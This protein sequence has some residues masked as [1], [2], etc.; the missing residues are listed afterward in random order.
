MN[1]Q[2]IPILFITQ[3][4]PPMSHI[5]AFRLFSYVK[6]FR[7]DKY[8][9]YVIARKAHKNLPGQAQMEGVSITY[10]E[11]DSLI[12]DLTIYKA[13]NRFHHKLISLKNKI[14][15]NFCMDE[16]PDFTQKAYKEA[17][18]MITDKGIRVVVTSFG[19]LSM[20]L[21]GIKI[22]Q[23]FKDVLWVSDLRDEV[24][25]APKISRLLKPRITKV[26]ASMM[27]LADIVVSV[28]KPILSDL[29]D[30]EFFKSKCLEV[31]NGFDFE[32]VTQPKEKGKMFTIIYAGSFYG[33]INPAQFFKGLALFLERTPSA[34]LEFQVFGGSD[35]VVIP[36][37]LSGLVKINPRVSHEEIVEILPK[38]DAFLLIY[39]TDERKGVYTGKLF[40][41]L[42]VERPILALVNPEDVAAR[43]IL[44]SGSGHVTDNANTEGIANLLGRAY[45][46]WS[47]GES[48]S[49]NWDTVLLHKRENQVRRLSTEVENL[50]R[51]KI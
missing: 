39:P 10:I 12:R 19:P 28:S 16:N 30:Y 4:F 15:F 5:A 21:L 3:Y 24:A 31:R 17:E 41:Y 42:A 45:R 32:P 22:K 2:K 11:S 46:A 8:E 37:S 27:K 36:K 7:K 49:R 9:V 35:G 14:I 38:A 13:K 51:G 44:E 40:D 26:E 23:R 25:M 34:Q 18:R 29:K 20:I 6:Y 48:T 1:Q 43:L 47:M 33:S 50:L